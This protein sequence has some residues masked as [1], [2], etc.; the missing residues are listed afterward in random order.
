MTETPAFSP[1]APPGIP[2]DP[3][4]AVG[5]L[6]RV[7]A[8]LRDPETGC[9]WDVAQ[10]LATIAPCVIEEAYEVADAIERGA[11]AD[12][13]EE[14]GDLL[15]QVMLCARI[16]EERGDFDLTTIVTTLQDKLIRR[17]P[18]V[19][20]SAPSRAAA[21]AAAR[22]VWEQVKAEERHARGAFGALEGLMVTGPA[23]LRAQKLADRTRRLA[24]TPSETPWTALRDAPSAVA[25][26]AS[27]LTA[28][29]A[30]TDATAPGPEEDDPLER[31][32][33]EALF[34]LA[35]LAV[36]TGHDCEQALRRACRCVEAAVRR[37]EQDAIESARP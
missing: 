36:H 16:A 32:L 33:G 31:C 8:R 6:H 13:R 2:T 35:A 26:V 4:R 11:V 29:T 19:F 22:A 28:L 14:L 25:V 34:G 30:R 7:I 1:A 17:H 24:W 18:H 23:L 21:P 37:Q 20:D 9:P 3:N 10:T 27:A 12:M 5:D 15:L